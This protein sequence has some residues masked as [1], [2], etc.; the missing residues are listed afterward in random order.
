MFEK[1]GKRNLVG[2][3]APASLAIGLSFGSVAAI[4]GSYVTSSDGDIVYNNFKECWNAATGTVKNVPYCGD[5][6]A[7]VPTPG[8]AVDS[9]GDGVTD[10]LDRCPNSLYG[11][12]VNSAGCFVD[13]DGDGVADSRDRC[14][15]TASGVAV[16]VEGCALQPVSESLHEVLGGFAFDKAD[17][18]LIKPFDKAKLQ[19]IAGRIKSMG[20]KQVHVIGYT[21]SIGPEDYNLIL[22]ERRAQTVADYL[23]SQGVLNLTVQGKGESNFIGD[24]DTPEGR[25]LN[26]RIEIT[27]R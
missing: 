21:D 14:P 1:A 8:P 6:A 27:V 13:G 7:P 25:A 4:A 15:D 12:V 16:D 2:L 23:A 10:D 24:N 9:D 22:S 17:T 3:V 26:R 5:A 18:L 20:D 11:A 19:R